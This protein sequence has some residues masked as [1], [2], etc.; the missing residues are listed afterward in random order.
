MAKIYSLDGKNYSFPDD[1]TVEEVASIFESMPKPQP[2][3]DQGFL[4]SMGKGF[5]ETALGA[6]KAY[7]GATEETYKRAQQQA[8]EAGQQ[9]G[10]KH[11]LPLVLALP[12]RLL[13][14]DLK[15]TFITM[16]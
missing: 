12:I 2:T 1:I 16:M 10:L 14:W 9:Q 7:G 4:E 5:L 6:S 8:E 3:P 15:A 13:T 11:C